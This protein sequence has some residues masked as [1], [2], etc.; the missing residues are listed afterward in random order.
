MSVLPVARQLNPYLTTDPNE[1]ATVYRYKAHFYNVVEKVCMV[2]EIAIMA[3]VLSATTGLLTLTGTLEIALI[4]LVISG[5]FLH[6]KSTSL[7]QKHQNLYQI[8]NFE[9]KV[10]SK[11]REISNWTE[12]Q[13]RQFFTDFGLSTDQLPLR[14]LAEICPGA[15]LKALLPPIARFICL[16][17][18][19]EEEKKSIDE[20][21]K[22]FRI[23]LPL[24][25]ANAAA[26]E[27]MSIEINT[28]MTL[29]KK[30]HEI[31]Y[32]ELIPH[33]LNAAI[34]LQII[35]DP[36]TNIRSFSDIGFCLNQVSPLEKY[37]IQQF[38]PGWDRYFFF[39]DANRIPLS[40]H[41]IESDLSPQ[42]L[43]Q[44]LFV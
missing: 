31:K 38:E 26:A 13:V 35:S 41:S 20:L 6:I 22:T 21:L 19:A 29:C 18:A 5:V 42:S 30:A 28:R 37:A 7:Y 4:G 17:E 27:R 23:P 14:R 34:L 9:K 40:L 32:G 1:T 3:L 33:A 44:K 11:L 2:A 8:S 43:R 39:R 16:K 36:Q 12:E 10:A 25:L 15:P 24:S